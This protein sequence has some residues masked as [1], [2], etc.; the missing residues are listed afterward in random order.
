M[1]DMLAEDGER[2]SRGDTLMQLSAPELSSQVR[3]LEAQRNEAALRLQASVMN[4]E[5][6]AM[7]RENL[8]LVEERLADARLQA[9]GLRVVSPRDGYLVMPEGEP[10]KGEHLARGTS[11]AVV[12]RDEDLRIR[13]MVPSH[14]GD[15]VRRDVRSVT[16]LR[17]GS[18][19]TVPSSVEWVSPGATHE[20]PH[21]ALA[22]PGGG[23]VALDPR[24]EEPLTAFRRHYLADF[25]AGELLDPD[26][27]LR[28]GERVRV[29]VEHPDEPLGFRWWRDLRR[30]FLS[31][32]DV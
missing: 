32:F 26:E 1:T 27:R 31:I 3:R 30:N 28:L 29:R 15:D 5:E 10:T 14:R 2:V 13:A 12:L 25:D 20:I 9:A 11:V 21:E 6:V 23:E 16:L 8:A 7:Q 18:Q 19:H 4:A 22:I 17:S 24:A